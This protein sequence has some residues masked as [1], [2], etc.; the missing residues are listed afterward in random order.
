V[1]AP[2]H[3]WTLVAGDATTCYTFGYSG[4]RDIDTGLALKSFL[5]PGMHELFVA[6]SPDYVKLFAEPLRVSQT[7]YNPMRH[8]I[9]SILF[10]R[11]KRP[12]VLVVDDYDKDGRPHDWRWSMNCAQGFAPGLDTRFIDAQGKGVY[13]SLAI[14]PGATSAE[15]VLLHSPIDDEKKRGQH[16]LPRLLVRDLGPHA[17]S[18]QPRI[19]LES[20]PPGGKGPFLTYGYDNNRAEKVETPVPTNRLLIERRNV[21]RPD[22]TVFLLPFRT[23]ERLPETAW[24]GDCSALTVNLGAAG[25]DTIRFDRREADHR[26]RLRLE[27]VQR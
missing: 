19:G 18:S 2:D 25:V 3:A 4:K 15:A 14:A 12:Y 7:D 11:G 13:S 16:G 23:G 8:A 22:Y 6:R 20:R 27:R 5:Y 9:R 10:V 24:N 17:V 1:E 26:T 21:T